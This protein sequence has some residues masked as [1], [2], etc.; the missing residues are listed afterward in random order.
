MKIEVK[1]YADRMEISGNAR[2]VVSRPAEAYT[3]TRLLVG[4]F[5]P[6]VNCLR[7]GLEQIGA[8]GLLKRKP[9]LNIRS[10]EK[11]L[12]GLSEIEERTLLEVGYSAGGGRVYVN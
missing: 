10:M 6:A 12:E 1:I 3:S 2:H 7:S 9:E 8:F 4:T 11:N 5:H